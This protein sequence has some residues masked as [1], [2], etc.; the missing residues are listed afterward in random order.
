MCKHAMTK[1]LHAYFVDS[2]FLACGWIVCGAP[3]VVVSSLKVEERDVRP[4][5]HQQQTHRM[6]RINSAKSACSVAASDQAAM[7]VGVG[8]G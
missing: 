5:Q 8:S 6:V 7:L 3:V 4:Q 2:D 1:A